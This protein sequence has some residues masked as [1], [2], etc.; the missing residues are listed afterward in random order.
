[1]NK[2]LKNFLDVYN[3]QYDNQN[4]HIDNFKN[5]HFRCL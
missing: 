2:N 1:M 3:N 4:K 5:T